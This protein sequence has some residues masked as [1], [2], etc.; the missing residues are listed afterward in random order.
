MKI[1]FKLGKFLIFFYSDLTMQQ[2][3]SKEDRK[4]YNRQVDDYNAR[5]SSAGTNFGIL[6]GIFFVITLAVPVELAPYSL[7]AAV[8]MAAVSYILDKTA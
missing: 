4:A 1:I 7:S 6:A 8:L 3:I 5:R 2:K